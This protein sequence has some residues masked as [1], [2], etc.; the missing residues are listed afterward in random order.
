MFRSSRRSVEIANFQEKGIFI[1]SP[2]GKIQKFIP[3]VENIFLIN[4]IFHA[5]M[6]TI[7]GGAGKPATMSFPQFTR[8]S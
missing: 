4:F 7:A 6:P 8:H 1:N 5:T 2:A 3:F